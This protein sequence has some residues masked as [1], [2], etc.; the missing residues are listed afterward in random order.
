M[1]EREDD[2]VLISDY[3]KCMLRYDNVMK[4]MCKE[5]IDVIKSTERL[6]ECEGVNKNMLRYMLHILYN[7]GIISKDEIIEWYENLM[8]K[9]VYLESQLMKDFI[10]WL[11]D[12]QRI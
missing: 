7:Q 9:S 4:L 12:D 11:R 1:N 5:G 3:K 6:I 10:E 2:R 8:C